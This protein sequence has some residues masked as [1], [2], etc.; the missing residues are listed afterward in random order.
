MCRYVC[1][2]FGV[3]YITLYL[4]QPGGQIVHQYCTDSNEVKIFPLVSPADSTRHKSALFAPSIAEWVLRNRESCCLVS[5]MQHKLYRG[6]IDR[7]SGVSNVK[8]LM[9]APVCD[10]SSNAAIGVFHFVN[11]VTKDRFTQVDEQYALGYGELAGALAASSAKYIRLRAQSERL[12]SLV[13]APLQL[14]D[15]FQMEEKLIASNVLSALEG[16]V[17]DALHSSHTKAF[18]I[19]PRGE[20]DAKEEVFLTTLDAPPLSLRSDQCSTQELKSFPLSTTHP[21]FQRSI[22]CYSA[23]TQQSYLAGAKMSVNDLDYA[24]LNPPEAEYN[25]EVDLDPTPI[26][27]KRRSKSSGDIDSS[28]PNTNDKVPLFFTVPII[29]LQ[30]EVIGCI[31]A[32]PSSISPP[33]KIPSESSSDK[34]VHT[35]TFQD[36]MGWLSYLLS[37]KVLMKL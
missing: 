32:S 34:E 16:T 20:D 4:V 24:T 31:Q 1:H 37:A 11:R 29:N 28:L 18:L 19:L 17:R 22:A 25:S 26:I 27:T 23:T 14:L 35:I 2:V 7:A 3:E 30:Q 12:C 13:Q 6:D 9:S 8:R 21:D 5:P 36:A 15:W 33:L 10:L